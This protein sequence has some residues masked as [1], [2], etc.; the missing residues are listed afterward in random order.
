M[1]KQATDVAAAFTDTTDEG[2]HRKYFPE[3]PEADDVVD[4][5][6][7]AEG[8]NDSVESVAAEVR[9]VAVDGVF[10]WTTWGDVLAVIG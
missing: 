1:Q 9:G 4:L 7:G 2:H 6:E 8:E 3:A 10:D 5:D